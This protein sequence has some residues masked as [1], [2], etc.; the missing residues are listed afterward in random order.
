MILF[1]CY[2]LERGKRVRNELDNVCDL[3]KK[4]GSFIFSIFNKNDMFCLPSDPVD[5]KWGY[6]KTARAVSLGIKRASILPLKR[7][8]RAENTLSDF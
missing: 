5:R 8:A 3:Q 7:C 4:I 1:P 2:A 6:M